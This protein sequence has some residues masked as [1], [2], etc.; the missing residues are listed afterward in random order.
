MEIEISEKKI[1][2]RVIS[3]LISTILLFVF[4]VLKINKI[5]L[6]KEVYIIVAISVSFILVVIY[7]LLKYFNNKS[8]I[9]KLYYQVVD[10]FWDVEHC[11][12]SYSNI[13]YGCILSCCCRW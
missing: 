11:F 2:R 10:F 7:G 13:L 9:L 8:D 3:L 6:I 12:V 4:L 5:Q 1:I